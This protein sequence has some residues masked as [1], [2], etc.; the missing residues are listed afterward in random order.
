MTK[1]DGPFNADPDSGRM[2]FRHDWEQRDGRPCI[3]YTDPFW[4]NEGE[5]LAYE[6]A[7]RA[8]RPEEVYH[9]QTT[10]DPASKTQKLEAGKVFVGMA[11]LCEEIAELAASMRPK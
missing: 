7:V 4:E 1:R 6:R 10:W 11:K 2:G 3:I 5:R 9:G 8:I